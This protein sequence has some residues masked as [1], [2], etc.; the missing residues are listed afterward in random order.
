M[1]KIVNIILLLN[2]IGIVLYAAGI[3]NTDIFRVEFL[4]SG[5]IMLL[6]GLRDVV[7]RGAK[8]KRR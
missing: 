4:S 2:V 1:T 8:R 5:V 7:V 6:F 3:L